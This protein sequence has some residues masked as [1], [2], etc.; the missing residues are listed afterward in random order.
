MNKV[1]LRNGEKMY[2]IRKIKFENHPI[3]KNLE[4]NFCDLNGKV[5]ETIIFAGENG[6]G[7]STI[8]NELYKI[9][10][11]KVDSPMEVE[12]EDDNNF[13]FKL[14][15][16]FRESNTKKN[17]WAKDLNAIEYI[18]GWENFKDKYNFN[19]IFSDVD[20]NFNAGNLSSVTS[21]NLDISKTSYR[22]SNDLPTKMNQLLI[23]VQSLDDSEIARQVKNNPNVPY[24]DIL[25]NERMT[26]FTNAFNKMFDNLS[27]SHIEN[28]NSHKSIVFEKYGIPIF[29]EN[30]SSGEKQIVYRGAFLLKDKEA[31]NG[32]FV[33]IDEPEISMHPNWQLKVM[34]FYKDIFTDNNGKQTSQIFVVTHSPF[35]IHNENRINDKVIV[36]ERDCNGNIIVK[37]KAEYFKCNSKEVVEDAFAIKFFD[38]NKSIVYLEG[39]TDEKYFNKTLEIFNIEAPFEFRWVG[40]I[41][42]NKSERNTGYRS[43]NNAFDFLVAQNLNHKNVCLYDSDTNKDDEDENNI[44]IRC[45]PKYN[46]SKKM[47]K[48][49]ENALVLDN[50]DTTSF[51]STKIKEGD[52]GDENIINEFDKMRFCEYI[53][54]LEKE[55]LKT[56]LLNLKSVIEKILLPIFDENE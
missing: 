56:I 3:L 52:Y 44:F 26:R 47:K 40:Y 41:D 22:S 7:K 18:E 2:R 42:E 55:K 34:N 13:T 28:V 24:Q 10:S 30:L 49:V 14:K 32:A 5:M 48:G 4:L 1:V 33:F 53:C 6:T 51:Y 39:R 21:L 31:M 37:D 16:Y 54:S 35:I 29:I 50:I 43:L 9:A 19:G 8:L 45:I 15:Y 46:N 23:D 12:F 27:Y 38:S 25:V 20:I 36:L 17:I 11:H